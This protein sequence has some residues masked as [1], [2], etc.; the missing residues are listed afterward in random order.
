[1]NYPFKLFNFLT[2]GRLVALFGGLLRQ[3]IIL[4]L[5]RVVFHLLFLYHPF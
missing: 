5:K 3:T 1:M 2:Q 4:S